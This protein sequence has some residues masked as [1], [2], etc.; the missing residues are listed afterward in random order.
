[1]IW[2]KFEKDENGCDFYWKYEGEWKDDMFSGYGT[3]TWDN[4]SIYKGDWVTGK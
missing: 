1:M 3:M 2:K 4:G